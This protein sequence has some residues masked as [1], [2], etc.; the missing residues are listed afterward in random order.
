MINVDTF[1]NAED[2]A[3]YS[4]G[5]FLPIHISDTFKDGRYTVVHKLGHGAYSTVWLVKDSL[6]GKYVSLKVP[7]ADASKRSRNNLPLSSTGDGA[8]MSRLHSD[9]GDDEGREHVMRMLD[10]FD[11]RGINGTHQCVVSE[12]LGCSLASLNAHFMRFNRTLTGKMAP[13]VVKRI[14]KQI[15][16]GVR[17][18]HRKGIVHG[19][20][21]HFTTS[22]YHFERSSLSRSPRK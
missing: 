15:C 1:F 16:Y 7:A 11:H 8:I 19:G 17:Y 14:F 3:Y 5:I 22:T 18:L 13:K 21:S 2:V 9:E 4:E 20:E 6:T 10:R 12:L